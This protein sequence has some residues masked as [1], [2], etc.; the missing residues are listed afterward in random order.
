MVRLQ[1][2][3]TN[4]GNKQDRSLRVVIPKEMVKLENLKMGDEIIFIKEDG[5]WVANFI[6]ATDEMRAYRVDRRNGE[7]SV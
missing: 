5:K 7:V 3:N 4:G 2:A 6:R 1:Y